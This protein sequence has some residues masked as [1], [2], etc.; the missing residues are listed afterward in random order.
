MGKQEVP[1]P[2]LI[3][4]V[5]VVL[6]AAYFFLLKGSGEETVTP[7][8]PPATPTTGA[9]G[10]TGATG[11]EGKADP[12]KSKAQKAK[13]R[14]AKLKAAAAEAGIPLDV[15]L[16]RKRGDVVAIFFFEPRG[17]VDKR[18]KDDVYLVRKVLRNDNNKYGISWIDARGEKIKI[19]M[20]VFPDRISNK[21]RYEGLA[22]AAKVSETPA[23]ILLYKDKAKLLQGYVDAS[24]IYE[25]IGQMVVAYGGKPNRKAIQKALDE[26]GYN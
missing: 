22:E 13:E 21:S 10:G 24:S 1:K 15:Y 12:E 6:A 7:P 14:D 8:P 19:R 3:A 9:T 18:V 26:I 16:A 5:V 25:T 2:L 17:A 20:V 11:A 23:L 4:L